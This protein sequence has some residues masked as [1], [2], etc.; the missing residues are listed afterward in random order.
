MGFFPKQDA[1]DGSGSK[2]RRI[3][4][5]DSKRDWGVT[6]NSE[7]SSGGREIDQ[8]GYGVLPDCEKLEPISE[9]N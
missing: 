1:E 6:E 7:E 4:D 5:G 2:R 9:G 8:E 3:G